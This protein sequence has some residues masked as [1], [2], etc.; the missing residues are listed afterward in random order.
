VAEALRATQRDRILAGDPPTAWAGMVV[1][2]DGDVVPLPGGRPWVARH[3]A[4][5]TAIAGGLLLL[6]ILVALARRTAFG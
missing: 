6:A 2:G 3:A 1:L 5:I 4:E